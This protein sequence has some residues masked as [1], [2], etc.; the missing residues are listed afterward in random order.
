MCLESLT[1]PEGKFDRLR[2]K[3][4]WVC[5]RILKRW[6]RAGLL[7]EVGKEISKFVKPQV[8]S[9]GGYG[10]VDNFLIDV[11]DRQGGKLI[12]LD[13]DP[14]H[15]P[16]IVCD[17]SNL[18][19]V[20]KSN[21]L[22]PDIIVALEVLEHVSNFEDAIRECYQALN[23]NG[24]F[25]IST[26]W[27]IP[28]NDRHNDYYRFTPAA[29]SRQLELFQ[30]FQIAARGDYRDSVIMLMLRGLFSGGLGGKVLMGI[31]ILASLALPL[32]KIRYQ[33]DEI[34]SCIGYLAVAYKH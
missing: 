29:L 19:D 4:W 25:I 32:P 26:P 20:L 18:T 24:V 30:T 33:T 23:V 8:V 22:Q 5:L 13:I 1:S 21:N 34:D 6:S 7:P 9:V 17:I 10:L 31:G 27:I 14:K 12:T 15:N 3:L 11:I 16:D 2:D 28:I